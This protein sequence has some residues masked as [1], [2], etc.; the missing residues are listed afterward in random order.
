[1]RLKIYNFVITKSYLKYIVF[2]WYLYYKNILFEI[3]L[4]TTIR[5][6]KFQHSHLLATRGQNWANMAQNQ[7]N[8]KHSTAIAYTSVKWIERL[9]FQIMVEI[10]GWMHGW[11]DGGMHSH[12]S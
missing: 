4:S 9:L 10:H 8:T 5:N 2:E 1:M 3:Y 11:A 12:H 6:N 7:I